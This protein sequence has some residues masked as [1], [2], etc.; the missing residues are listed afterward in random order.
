[1]M[2]KGSK[3]QSE[4]RADHLG[5]PLMPEEIKF[6]FLAQALLENDGE[7]PTNANTAETAQAN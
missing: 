2:A 4:R 5:R 7:W 1:M 3:P 6:L